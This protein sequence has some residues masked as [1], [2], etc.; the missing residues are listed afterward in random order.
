MASGSDSFGWD[1][2]LRKTDDFSSVFR[3]RRGQRGLGLDVLASPNGM[4]HPRLGL[5]VPKKVLDRAVERNRAR[6]IFREVFRLRQ[7]DLGGVDMIVRVKLARAPDE[8]RTECES[9][10]LAASRRAHDTDS[11]GHK[12]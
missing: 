7:T 5:I 3:F 9:L 10:L 4:N 6:R 12:P 1:K 11:G 8:Y 2:K